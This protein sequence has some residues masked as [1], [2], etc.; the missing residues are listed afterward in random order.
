MTERLMSELISQL[1]IT[2]Q[3]DFLIIWLPSKLCDVISGK[4]TYDNYE[5]FLH[6]FSSY[7]WFLMDKLI[8][9]CNKIELSL[10]VSLSSSFF[11]FLSTSFVSTLLFSSLSS[12]S[13]TYPFSSY[14]FTSQQD[15]ITYCIL[16]YMSWLFI[17]TLKHWQ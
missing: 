5:A 1:I 11:K 4:L 10:L 7:H 2:C 6:L 15:C 8:N 12:I 13:S 9:S 3:S 14:V 16:L 17:F